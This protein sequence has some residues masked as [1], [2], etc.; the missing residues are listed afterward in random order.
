MRNR[1]HPWGFFCIREAQSFCTALVKS[2]Q[3]VNAIYHL[4]PA[5]L[6]Y[7]KKSVI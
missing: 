3:T 4:V 6:L 1:T 5:D 2:Q 7:V